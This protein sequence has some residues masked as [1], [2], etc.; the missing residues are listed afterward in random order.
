MDVSEHLFRELTYSLNAALLRVGHDPGELTRVL[1]QILDREGPR[2][3]EPELRE[4]WA[5]AAE[6]T[7]HELEELLEEAVEQ[8]VEELEDAEEP[9]SAHRLLDLLAEEPFWVLR[10]EA[11]AD[12]LPIAPDRPRGVA[13]P[14]AWRPRLV[15]ILDQLELT[16][17]EANQ[18]LR[19]VHDE[20]PAALLERALD[21]AM[22]A[23]AALEQSH[24]GRAP[25][26]TTTRLP[27]L[28]QALAT[29]QRWKLS[30]EYDPG[31]DEDDG[32]WTLRVLERLYQL[33]W[34]APTTSTKTST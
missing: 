17:F 27:T 8:V 19:S 3:H 23:I 12:P 10:F 31:P 25:S 21:Q 29:I 28:R 15:A 24:T 16:L 1:L 32:E 5:A 7:V 30:V 4:R 14:L 33:E 34:V 20:L 18:D 11:A 9:W 2:H 6:V 26:R 22:Q 13:L